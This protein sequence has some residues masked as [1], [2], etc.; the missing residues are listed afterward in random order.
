MPGIF[1]GVGCP[2]ALYEALRADFAATYGKSEAVHT[3]GGMLGGHAFG[4]RSA[5]HV[6][7][8]GGHFAVDGEL[9]IY[10]LAEDFARGD[11]PCFYRLRSG[12]LDLEPTCKGN[13]A[14]IDPRSGAWHA[15]D[16][17]SSRGGRDS[18]AKAPRGWP[19]SRLR[20]RHGCC[21]PTRIGSVSG[22]GWP[23]SSSRSRRNSRVSTRGSPT[24]HSPAARQRLSSMQRDAVPS[25][26]VN[27][28]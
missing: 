28:P 17:R 26:C 9:S 18:K 19:S 5:L 16:P 3:A 7:P 6:A 1:G 8:G 21:A 10:R 11:A 25:S 13:V 27:K 2:P 4:S 22:N 23:R 24:R 20:G 12:E 14:A 15:S